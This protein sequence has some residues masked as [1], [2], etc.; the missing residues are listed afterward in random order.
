MLQT[1]AAPRPGGIPGRLG[2]YTPLQW[3][4]ALAILGFALLFAAVLAVVA[5]QWL[6]TL[7][8]MQDF[9][10]RFPG[11]YHL[12]EGAPVGLP[13]WLGWQHFFNVFLILL[14]I[15]S[16]IRVRTERRPEAFWAS[17]RHP[18][19]K[20]SIMVWFHNAVDLLW[21][22]NGVVYVVLLFVTGQW[23]RIVPTSWEVFPNALS[24]GLQYVSLNWPTENG[25]VNY[26]G[27]QQLTYFTTV[28]IAAPLAIITGFRM[29]EWWPKNAK[30]LN[31]VYPAAVAR[32]LHFPVMLYFVF[33]ILTHVALV[34]ST[35]ALRNLNH[36][37]AS[38]DVVNWT[39]FWLFLGSLV[40]FAAAL[41]AARP[42]VIAPLARIFGNVSS[43]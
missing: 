35:G 26:N 4:G 14:I 31:K 15:R 43:R 23:V 20:I 3:L 41:I 42:I 24:A 32:A 19:R 21:V 38:Q 37:Y 39:G 2:L 9:M 18:Q 17:R 34:L 40:L 33:F 27:L 11:E 29:S 7:D 36:I 6:L 12:P 28:F 8:F 5:V 16:G 30:F 13:S 1:P 25:W 10:E 22:I